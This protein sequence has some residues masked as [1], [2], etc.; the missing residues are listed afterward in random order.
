MKDNLG[1]RN[2][3]RKDDP[4]PAAWRNYIPVDPFAAAMPPISPEGLAEMVADIREH[5]I[6]NEVTIYRDANGNESILDGC[7]RLDAAEAAGLPIIKDGALNFDVVPHRYIEGNVDRK[8]YI[9]AQ[10]F[11]RRHLDSE[12]KRTAIAKLLA[13]DPERSD[14][15]IGREIGADHK[16]VAAER[17]KLESTGEIPQSETRR[18]KDGRIRPAHTPK[19]AR[20]GT[21][22]FHRAAK[23]GE[24]TVSRLRGTSLEKARE[25]DELII[26]NR[27]A[28]PGEHTEVVQRLIAAAIAGEQV[29]AIAE[30]KRIVSG[31]AD[32]HDHD[33]DG[34]DHANENGGD[35]HEQPDDDLSEE[36]WARIDAE[37]D[38]Q[39]TVADIIHRV[40]QV[41]P[42]GLNHFLENLSP[43]QTTAIGVLLGVRDASEA[44]A[45]ITV[46]VKECLSHRESPWDEHTDLYCAKLA[47]ITTL[48]HDA[49]TTPENKRSKQ[50]HGASRRGLGKAGPPDNRF[51]TITMMS[52]SGVDADG[53]PNYGQPPADRSRATRS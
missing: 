45:A 38:L 31:S 4:K 29:S 10:N 8:A 25:L 3:S 21:P 53:N 37:S 30:G 48:L 44:V 42:G 49:K 32:Q 14:R 19:A 47:E 20:S 7:N 34:R 41:I 51:D 17:T 24:D 26:L 13:E 5:G 50:G 27:G 33:E 15:D 1:A 43:E 39:L 28:P 2:S 12:Q 23:L 52:P 11:L 40:T 36:E 6:W 46:V 35:P 9:R 18:S 16:T 22:A